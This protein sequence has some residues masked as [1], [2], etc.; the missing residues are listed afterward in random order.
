MVEEQQTTQAT[1]PRR[2]ALKA[3]T[4]PPVI[5]V[6]NLAQQVQAEPVQVIKQLMRAGVFANINQAVDFE[7]AAQVARLFGYHAKQAEEVGRAAAAAVAEED[8]ALL[9]ERPPVVTILGHVDHGK[10]TLL[11]AV[12]QTNVVAK[13]RGGITQHIGAYQVNYKDHPITFLDT[14]GHEAFTAMRARGAQVTDI[15]VLVVAA[16]DGMMPQT[17][18]AIDHVKA[19]GVP[20]LVAI[21]KMDLPDADPERVKRQLS[22]HELLVEDWGGDVIAV[23][24]SAKGGT[25]LDDLLE[26]I[27]VVAEVAE[28]KANPDREAVGVV[29]EAWTDPRRGPLATVLVQTGTLQVADTVVVG[30]ARGRVRALVNDAGRRIKSAGPATPVEVLGIGQLPVVGDRLIVVTDERTAR[31]LVEERLRAA[32]LVQAHGVSLEELQSQLSS[33]L[34]RELNL[35]L[36]TDVQGSID[37]VQTSLVQL[38]TPET[39]VKLI[40]ATTGSITESDVLLA[41]ASHAIIVG[42]NTR[43]EPGA[44]ALAEREGVEIRHYDIIYRLTED[45]QAALEGM[46]EP[47]IQDVVEGRLEVRA[48]FPLGKSR[49]SA[50]CY[51]VEGQISR[52]SMVR[53][54]RDGKQLFD[55]PV[56]SLRRF[57]DDVR[58]VTASYECGVALDGFNAFE[59]GDIIEPH[60][61]QQ[62]SRRRS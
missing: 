56:V 45:I 44:R 58:E 37:A 21:N 10:T 28:L 46:L 50:G 13:E 40:H 43:P 32:Q 53:L 19:A 18:E 39:Q 62:V 9:K 59:V 30:T 42:F 60:R 6:G 23:P 7:T 2:I 35:V 57:K 5:T 4:L 15:A 61:E 12:R 8:P 38:S 41:I 17:I 52:S 11:D 16:D 47:A 55:G 51:V 26:S 27:L 3:L 48:I 24:V 31:E 33:G 49:V 36:K 29:V 14:P 25:G 1:K 22:E 54:L 20:I 34:A